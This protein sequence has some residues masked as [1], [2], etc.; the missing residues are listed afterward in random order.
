A[1][2]AAGFGVWLFA[3]LPSIATVTEYHPPQPLRIYSRDGRLIGQSGPEYRLVRPLDAIPRRLRRAFLAA[4]DASFY[5]HPGID[6]GGILRALMADIRAGAFVQGGSTITQQVA[7]TFLLTDARTIS[8]KLR[9]TAL[10]LEIEAALSKRQI[11]QR[12]LNQIYLG[13]GAY[14][15]AAAAR[16]Y[17]GKPLAD[18]TLA[19]SATLAALPKGPA[20]FNPARHPERARQRRDYVLHQMLDQG[21]AK[22]DRVLAA[23]E[24]PVHA[25]Y[26]P[27]VAQPLPMVRRAVRKRVVDRFGQDRA[28][29]GG[30]RVVTS[31]DYGLQR[32]AQHQVQKGLL[33]FTRR[34][35]FRGP[36]DHWPLAELPGAGPARAR[37]QEL[38]APGPLRPALV[39]GFADNRA[40]RA[41]LADGRRIQVPWAGVRWA[42]P[43]RGQ[44]RR[45]PAPERPGDVLRP[46]DVVYLGRTRDRWALAQRPRVE[47]ALVAMDPA[48]GGVRALVGAF[49]P[50]RS[51]YNRAL[52]ARRQPGS[53]F[54][55]FLYAAALKQGLTPATLINDAPVVF[56]DARQETRWTPENYSHTFHG[57]TRL[58]TGLVHSRNLVTLRLLRRI[59]LEQGRRFAARFGFDSSRL[60]DNLSLGLGSASLTPLRMTAGYAAF[61]NGGRRV[62]PFLIRRVAACDGRIL[63][64]RHPVPSLQLAPDALGARVMSR[65]VAF[66]MTDLMKGVVENGTGWRVDRRMERPVAGKTGT[67]NRQRDAWFMGFTPGLATGVWVGFDR[68]RSLGVHE[69]GSRAA[70]PIWAGFM[71]AAL[72]DQP[73]QRFQRPPGLIRV[74]IDDKTGLLA[75]AG[76]GDTRFEWFREGNA[77]TRVAGGGALARQRGS[78][79]KR[80]GAPNEGSGADLSNLF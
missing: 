43:F 33:A 68:P 12:Y 53:A 69:T 22:P 59:G 61:A 23:L 30:L 36:V 55:P 63:A 11:L 34:H 70:S 16:T 8:R 67:A 50:R 20:Y 45:G 78:K 64:R 7:R 73:V 29:T 44:R 65:D 3:S 32:K 74:R 51:H 18:L 72:A 1:A 42:R 4:E 75:S 48:N 24:R 17:Y 15:V 9:E 79:G 10:A 56:Q 28:A 80:G 5:H 41:L 14:G 54:K 31:I 62:E 39:L 58:R 71:H 25:R 13:S 19:E 6:P 77:P 57:P 26:H 21:W 46:G 66:Q 40:T 60:P 37:L 2:V 52:R 27:P 76:S 35:G 49:D 47:S 38:P